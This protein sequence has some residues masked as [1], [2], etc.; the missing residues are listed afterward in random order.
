MLSEEMVMSKKRFVVFEPYEVWYRVEVLADTK[1][2][3]IAKAK[4][5][6]FIG[7]WSLDLDTQAPMDAEW[8]AYSDE[9]DDK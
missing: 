1:E 8:D 5:P 2:E 7:E 3:A 9:E 4:H 6:S